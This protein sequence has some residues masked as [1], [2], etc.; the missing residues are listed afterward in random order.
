MTDTPLTADDMAARLRRLGIPDNATVAVAVSGGA[1]SLCLLALMQQVQPVVALTVDHGLRADSAAEAAW[2]ADHSRA[3]GV[4]HVTL[5]WRPETRPTGNIQ[6]AAREARYALIADWCHQQGVAYLATAHHEDDQAETVL[7]R[8]ARGSGVYGLAAMVPSRELVPGLTLVRPLLDVPKARLVATLEDRG[9]TW[10]EDPSNRSESFDRI[11]V[12]QLLADPPIEGLT[13]ARLARTA[14]RM[15]RTKAALA[16]Y[17]QHW[18]DAHVILDAAGYCLLTRAGLEGVPEEI[19]LRGLT[20]CLRFAGGGAYGPRIEKTERLLAALRDSDFAGATLNG[21]QLLK[22]DTGRILVMREAAAAEEPQPVKGP[23]FFDQRFDVAAPAAA[24]RTAGMMIGLLGE[25][26]V[27]QL[28]RQAPKL[29]EDNRL[30]PKRVWSVL[31]AFYAGE[32]L[33]AV[34][35]LGYS[36]GNYVVPGLTHRWLPPSKTG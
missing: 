1:D 21:V 17:E 36:D 10:I 35:H 6:A 26:G 3:L 19:V 22:D 20:H 29:L 28:R 34:P 33:I 2:V 16:H 14:A 27:A 30:P 23:L 15:Q 32:S 13:P 12:R 11:K 4:E 8:L 24:E 25:Q 18:F 9:E 31:P 5:T 7:L